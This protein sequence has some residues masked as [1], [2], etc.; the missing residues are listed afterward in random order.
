MGDDREA[1]IRAVATTSP[2]RMLIRDAP[3]PLI[4]K[5]D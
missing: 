4:S 3:E 2:Q 1:A 5:L